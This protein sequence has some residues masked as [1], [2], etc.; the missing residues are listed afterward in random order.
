MTQTPP[1]DLT[2]TP[3]APG[4]A[5]WV[6]GR[7][8]ALYHADEGYDARFEALVARILADFLESHDPACECGLIARQAGVRLGSVFV[9]REGAQVARLRLF[10]LEPQA[11]GLGLG[12]QMLTAAMQFARTAGY[13]RMVLWTHE[14]HRAA[15]QLYEAM[16]WRLTARRAG[17]AFGQA[18]VDLEY[19]IDL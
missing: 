12:R 13:R 16:G 7:H 18:V 9:V 17:E 14:S 4:D 2:L 15:C 8:G 3:L 6:I 1:P 5:G 19:E 10:F 11:R